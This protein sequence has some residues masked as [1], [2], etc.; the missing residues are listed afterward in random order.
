MAVRLDNKNELELQTALSSR[1]IHYKVLATLALAALT[2]LSF[3]Q[4][5]PRDHA[6]PPIPGKTPPQSSPG[7]QPHLHPPLVPQGAIGRSPVSRTTGGARTEHQLSP[8][9]RVLEST[10]KMSGKGV[11]HAV[12]YGTGVT[13][14]VEHP[15]KPG[16]LSRTYVQGGHVLYARV[17]RQSTFQRFGRAFSYERLVPAITFGAAYYAWATRPWSTSVSYRWRWETEPWYAAFGGNFTPY[18]NYASLDEWLTDYVIAQNLRDAYES[19]Q[20]E[21]AP[22][23][24]PLAPV[25]KE[26]PP[27]VGGRP[28]WESSDPGQRPYWESSDAADQRPYWE[29]P[30]GKDRPAQPKSSK[31]GNPAPDS[32]T[33]SQ[34][35][36]PAEDSPPPLSGEIKTR[37][38]TQIKQQLVERQSRATTSDTEDLPDSLKPGHTL[39][40]VNN[41]LDVAA[42]VSGQY[43][44][45]RA[46]DYIERIGEMDE[47]GMVP[48]KVMVGAISDCSV[49]LVTSV[50]VNDLEAMEAEQQQAVTDA[51]LAASKSMGGRGLPQAPGATPVLL[52][53]GQTHPAADATTT[54]SQLR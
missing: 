17:Y 20:A 25:A 14:I 39:F 7:S 10:Q 54:L 52:A 29:E 4:N 12:R 21:N 6:R 49:G 45:L 22:E 24:R 33:G 37:L 16:Y 30:S 40:R 18:P 35:R 50:S 31:T 43:C 13:G 28:Y 32:R 48:V 27:A 41:P 36:P 51:L 11:L 3:A 8:N 23:N 47:N 44:S 15:I 2:T 34:S 42:K 46:N 5:S 53:D 38:N 1:T 19:S 9:H 26:A